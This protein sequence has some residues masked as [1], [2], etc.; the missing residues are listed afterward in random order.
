ME[1]RKKYFDVVDGSASLPPCQ[2]HNPSVMLSRKPRLRVLVTSDFIT[3]CH[4]WWLIN[5]KNVFL[6]SGGWK[7]EIR[8]LAQPGSDEESLPGCRFP[9]YCSSL[10][11]QRAEPGTSTLS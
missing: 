7:S 1:I 10:M 6:T 8:L 2:A 5:N 9:I 11:W 4:N 3:K